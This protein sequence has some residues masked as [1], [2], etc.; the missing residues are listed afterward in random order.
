MS[1]VDLRLDWCSYQAA[2]YAVEHWHYS[3]CMPAAKAVYVGVWES[4][5]FIGC[6]IFSR[7]ANNHIGNLYGLQQTEVCELTRVAL[8]EHLSPVS[9]ITAI[10]IKMLKRLSP[11]IRLLVSYA[12][13]LQSHVGIVYQAMNWIYTGKTRAQR[14]A[15]RPDGSIEHKR[16]VVARLGTVS[17]SVYSDLMWKYKYLYPLDDT[18]RA[19]IAPLAQPYPKR[20]LSADSG[21]P[22]VQPGSGSAILTNAL[23]SH[24]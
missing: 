23:I 14:F 20:A 18:M 11:G 7:G 17:G 10:A 8:T 3:H 15:L 5:R 2:K 21:T 4:Q 19:Q 6:V 22:G 13:P 12:D 24:D 9:K 16:S 1:K